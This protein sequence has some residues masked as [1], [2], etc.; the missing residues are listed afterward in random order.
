MQR[1]GKLLQTGNVDASAAQLS[2]DCKS[3][4]RRRRPI[5]LWCV[6]L[7]SS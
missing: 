1:R 4:L 6:P 7:T 3:E 5:L 2:Y